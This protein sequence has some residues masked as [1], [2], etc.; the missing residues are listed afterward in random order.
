MKI[1]YIIYLLIVVLLGYLIFNRI[2]KGKEG[3]QKN[4]IKMQSKDGTTPLVSVK[5]LIVSTQDFS[6]DLNV[7]GSIEANEQVQI[8]S[9]VAGLVRA[10]NF[11]EGSDVTK[12]DLLIKI[13][14]R[15]LKAQLLQAE[16]KVKLAAQIETRARKLLKSE[17]ISQEEYE[18][19]NAE[20]RLLQAQ[21]QLIEAQLSKTE[22]RAPFSGRIGL[23]NISIGSYI[24]PSTEIVTLL[25]VNP[26]KITF[27]IPEKYAQMVRIGS[28]ISFTTAGN[29]EVF[30]AKIYAKEPAISVATRTLI[31][32]AKAQNNSRLLLPGS[33]ANINLP[34]ENIKDAI[35]IPTEAVIPILKGKQVFI[36]K[37]GLA[38]A[39]Q[40]TSEIR[41]DINVLVSS[42]LAV[43]DTVLTSGIM[44][45]KPD[46]PVSVSIESVNKK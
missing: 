46:A 29:S 26:V 24:T 17:A 33:F 14:N 2:N 5:G 19:A 6:N 40:I 45:I 28:E 11:K 42:G 36:C 16:T 39:V 23:T 10:V 7:S 13:D 22:I 25:S 34:L 1:K 32:K 18:N 3:Q 15:E 21:T 8:R 43:G 4:G 44:A 37:N 30:T 41:T 9:E 38:K 27:S 31:L 12:G 20:L 35:L